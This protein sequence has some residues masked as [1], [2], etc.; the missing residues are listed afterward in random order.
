MANKLWL[1]HHKISHIHGQSVFSRNLSWDISWKY[2]AIIFFL[3]AE[4]VH[5][6]FILLKLWLLSF[7]F[8][9]N[10]EKMDR[11]HGCLSWLGVQ[12]LILAQVMI[13][14][15]ETKPGLRLYTGCGV[16]LEFCLS[17]SLCL[18]LYLHAVCYPL[19]PPL[20]MRYQRIICNTCLMILW[21][22][23]FLA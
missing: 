18:S 10:K 20:S 11:G 5:S 12:L 23:V 1:S 4:L 2:H 19:I 22:K 7:I 16:R 21:F 6:F 17:L 3:W 9:F 15:S 13:S 14:G 8:P